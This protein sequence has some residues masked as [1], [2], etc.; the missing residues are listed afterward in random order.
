MFKIIR[1]SNRV[2][3]NYKSNYCKL[4]N[5]TLPPSY[6]KLNNRLYDLVI[7]TQRVKIDNFYD[8]GKTTD[9][10]YEAAEKGQC[11]L[12]LKTSDENIL[13]VMIYKNKKNEHYDYIMKKDL[14]F[15]GHFIDEQLD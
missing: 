4:N 15:K 3:S 10:L 7:K 1:I 5:C 11:T 2:S 9:M 13:D 14:S 6:Y 12:M 8:C